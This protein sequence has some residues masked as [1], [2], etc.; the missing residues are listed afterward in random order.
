MDV[1]IP[2][3]SRNLGNSNSFPINEKEDSQ[4]GEGAEREWGREKRDDREKE[5]GS[6]LQRNKT[7]KKTQFPNSWLRGP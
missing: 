4:K 1:K 3:C 5:E 2:A 6:P 7:L